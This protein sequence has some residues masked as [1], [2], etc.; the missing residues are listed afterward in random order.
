MLILVSAI[1]QC[2]WRYRCVSC[3]LSF[4]VNHIL[5]AQKALGNSAGVSYV[6]TYVHTYAWTWP[7]G[8]FDILWSCIKWRFRC[9][10]NVRRSLLPR[11]GN[12]RRYFAQ[13]REFYIPYRVRIL[14]DS[15]QTKRIAPEWT[16]DIKSMF[17]NHFWLYINFILSWSTL[18]FLTYKSMKTALTTT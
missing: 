17:W 14:G 12:S 3:R 1:S 9:A 2:E 8:A 16:R 15:R 18:T 6:L 10:K 7:T 4:A 13:P 11:G 5:R